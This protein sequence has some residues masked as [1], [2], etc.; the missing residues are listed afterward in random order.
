MNRPMQPAPGQAAAEAAADAH[1]QVKRKEAIVI[2]AAA[3]TLAEVI[4]KGLP[5]AGDVVT[6]ESAFKVAEAFIVEAERRLG[7]LPL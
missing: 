2:A 5:P 1:Y 7:K 4:G 3:L 6:L